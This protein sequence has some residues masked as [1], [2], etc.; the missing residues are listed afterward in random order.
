MSWFLG[1]WEVGLFFGNREGLVFEV[2]RGGCDEIMLERR[3]LVVWFSGYGRV[4]ILFK[5]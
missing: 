5:K 2:D 3:R 4:Y 1:N